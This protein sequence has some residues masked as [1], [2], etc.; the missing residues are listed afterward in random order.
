[1][2]TLITLWIAVLVLLVLFLARSVR[3]AHR[4]LGCPI[5]RTNARVTLLEA[6]PEGRP[7]ALTECSEFS[8][9]T[10]IT[11]DRNCLRPPATR[12]ARDSTTWSAVAARRLL[13]CS[14]A[15]PVKR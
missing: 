14:A 1:M 12:A 6:L 10:A 13:S 2:V 11:C 7:I 5:R 3:T 9:T 15:I 8:P 4:V